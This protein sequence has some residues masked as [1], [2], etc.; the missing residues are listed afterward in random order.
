MREVRILK[1]VLSPV[2]QARIN[3]SRDVQ[4]EKDDD[5]RLG[6]KGKAHRLVN[7]EE[8]NERSHL[9]M[10][11]AHRFRMLA[12]HIITSSVSRMSQWMRLKCH[13]PTT[14]AQGDKH[15]RCFQH[16]LFHLL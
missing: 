15:K 7:D 11:M 10:L 6:S 13:S 16:T 1:R 9:S 3:H 5:T 8:K 4:R 2:V 12:V 14:F